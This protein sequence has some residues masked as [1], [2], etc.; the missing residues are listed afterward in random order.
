ML[1]HSSLFTRCLTLA[2]TAATFIATVAFAQSAAPAPTANTPLPPPL[3]LGDRVLRS[4]EKLQIVP[5]L[6]VVRDPASYLAAISAW[7]PIRRYPV[8]IDDGSSASAE[9]IGRFAR[10]FAPEKV[11]SWS[12]P[13]SD[14]QTAFAGVEIARMKAAVAGAWGVDKSASD[15]EFILALR[16]QRQTPPGIVI[17]QS[18]DQAWTAGVAVAAFRGL[19]IADAAISPGIDRIASTQEAE[20]F[21]TKIEAAAEAT[22]LS[23]RGLGDNLDA[24]LLASNAPAKFV[25]QGNESL[26]LTDRVGRLGRGVEVPE[27]W[28]WCGQIFGDARAACYRAMCG[29]F[30]THTGAWL[31]DGYPDTKPWNMYDCT[32]AAAALKESGIKCETFD[33]PNQSSAAWRSRAAKPVDADLVLI[34]SKGNADFFDVEPGQCKPGDVPI[35]TKP[36]AMHIVHSWSAFVPGSRDLLAGRWLE[37]GAYFY[38]GSVHEP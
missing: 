5:V 4:Y 26:A 22:G 9:D 28:A 36:I 30:L 25:K 18:G 15:Q 35:L 37:R 21:C 6:V 34:N 13:G 11:V 3:L 12:E 20:D 19:P 31:F 32:A 2:F 14:A 27:R 7:T 10:A 1:R 24:V 23:W 8:L 33:T 29:L 16:Q 38:V 17:V